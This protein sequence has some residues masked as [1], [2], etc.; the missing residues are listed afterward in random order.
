MKLALAIA[1]AL[2]QQAGAVFAHAGLVSA[3]P[4]ADATVAAPPP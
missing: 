2:S 4:A 1:L 3:A